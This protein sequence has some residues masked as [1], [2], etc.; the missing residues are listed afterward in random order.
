MEASVS[1][2]SVSGVHQPGTWSSTCHVGIETMSLG[3]QA[4]P[5]VELAQSQR[6]FLGTLSVA[7]TSSTDPGR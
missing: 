2:V 3:G 6:Q 4:V 1:G 5:V 7:I